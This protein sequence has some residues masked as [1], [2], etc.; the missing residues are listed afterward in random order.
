MSIANDT[1]SKIDEPLIMSR[2]EYNRF[3]IL[4]ILNKHGPQ[5]FKD[6]ERLAGKSPRGLNLMLKD[7]LSQKRIAKIIHEGHQAYEIT[8]NGTK[9]YKILEFIYHKRT[10]M[11]EDGGQYHNDYSKQNLSVIS[12]YYPWGIEDDLILDKTMIDANPITKDTAIAVNEFLFEKICDDVKNKKIKLDKTKHGSVILELSIDYPELIKSIER[13]SLEKYK[14]VTKEELDIC[15]NMDNGTAYDEERRLIHQYREGKIT[16]AKFKKHLKAFLKTIGAEDVR[17]PDEF[18]THHRFW[19]VNQCGQ[20][21][22]DHYKQT[23][24][25]KTGIL[26]SQDKS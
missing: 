22:A 25:Y 1:L 14:K 2:K 24:R 5:R 6:L 26:S 13:N 17:H 23:Q 20:E 9:K 18:V 7:L 16:Y 3:K 12:T 15:E 8:D 11:L 4:K 19:N 21:K 10:E